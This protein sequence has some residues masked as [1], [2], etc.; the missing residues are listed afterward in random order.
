LDAGES[1]SLDGDAHGIE[2]TLRVMASGK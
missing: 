2:N 1:K